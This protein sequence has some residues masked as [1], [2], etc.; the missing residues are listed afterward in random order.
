M[1]YDALTETGSQ[2]SERLNFAWAQFLEHAEAMG[3][4]GVV[5]NVLWPDK[6]GFD[7]MGITSI[8]MVGAHAP[9]SRQSAVAHS[10][11][12]LHKWTMRH[13]EPPRHWFWNRCFRLARWIDSFRVTAR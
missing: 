4:R 3:A 5:V 2:Q 8:T 1:N 9:F 13:A 12:Q 6:D 10:T 11:L 7:R